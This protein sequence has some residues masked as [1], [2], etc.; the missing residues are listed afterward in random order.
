MRG[1]GPVAIGCAVYLGIAAIFAALK[2]SAATADP[3]LSLASVFGFPVAIA[4]DPTDLIALAVLPPSFAAWSACRRRQPP[5]TRA[6]PRALALAVAALSIVATSGPPQ[7]SVSAIA[8]DGSGDVY[9]TVESSASGDGVYIA[10]LDTG[11]WHRLTTAQA[12][13]WQT[14]HAGECCTWWA[15]SP[16]PQCIASPR[17]ALHRSDLR[18]R[19]TAPPPRTDRWFWSSRPGPP[20]RS[21]SPGTVT[22]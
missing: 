16:S 6:L 15:R 21:C 1:K 14:R 7:P 11:S 18:I 9:A 5:R 8:I 4:A 10:D 17:R 13:S 3:L 12:A 2:L 20:E 22:C 19:G